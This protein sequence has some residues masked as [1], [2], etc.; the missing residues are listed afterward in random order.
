[1]WRCMTH[2]NWAIIDRIYCMPRFLEK[3]VQYIDYNQWGFW[4]SIFMT[5]H[6]AYKVLVNSFVSN[7]LRMV[8]ELHPHAKSNIC[9]IKLYFDI[10]IIFSFSFFSFVYD[11]LS[12]IPFD[13]N[14]LSWLRTKFNNKWKVI[15]IMRIYR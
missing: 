15:Q 14:L 10:P 6:L 9:L 2:S 4:D 8:K 5:T 3:I 13:N 1:M 7:L 11:G 12:N